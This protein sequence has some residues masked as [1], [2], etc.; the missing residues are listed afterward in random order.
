LIA[1][2]ARF[3]LA[4]ASRDDRARGLAE[5]RAPVPASLRAVHPSWIEAGLADLPWRARDV[6]AGG[7]HTPAEVWLARWACAELPPLPPLRDL[8]RPESLADA[9]AMVRLAD[10]L[11]AIGRAQLA[12]AASL[13]VPGAP[14]KDELG[15]ARAVIAR[16][17]GTVDPLVIGARTIAGYTDVISARQLAVRLPRALALEAELAAHAT[18]AAPT[19]AAL[20]TALGG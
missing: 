19:W 7:A 3:G 1:L 17:R 2:V 13:A 20:R 18:G 4:A 9:I 12:Y 6:L 8:A 11:A 15:P 10:W 14:R 16:C 5:L